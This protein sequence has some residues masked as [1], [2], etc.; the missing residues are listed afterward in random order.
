MHS[1][2]SKVSYY[3]P[4]NQHFLDNK[5]TTQILCHIFLQDQSRCALWHKN[6]YIHILQ[7]RPWGGGGAIAPRSQR[8]VK[9][10]EAK[11][12]SYPVMMSI[13]IHARG[14]RILFI[15][16]VQYGVPSVPKYVIIN[17]KSTNSRQISD[18]SKKYL[19]N[20]SRSAC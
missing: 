11:C 18:N 4:K 14:S 9:K 2:C 7:G 1:E 17:L 16:T 15:K 8:N 10:M 3:Q 13:L 5:P 20:Q 6:K 12:F 19:P